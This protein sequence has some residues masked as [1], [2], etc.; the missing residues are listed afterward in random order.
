[1]AQPLRLVAADVVAALP[2][3]R[4]YARVLIG[5]WDGADQLVMETLASAWKKQSTLAPEI[6]LPTWLFSLMHAAHRRDRRHR[7]LA[8]TRASGAIHAGED[9]PSKRRAGNGNA[10]DATAE[11]WMR[12]L[13][14]P[15]EEREVL[16][17]AA[18][19]RLSYQDIA[20][21]L[22][23]PMATVM[24]TLIRARERMSTMTSLE[25]DSSGVP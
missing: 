5:D 9:E 15:V 19:E 1:M 20:T 7:G 13:R 2:R 4:R 14:L 21:L 23:V 10:G 22:D 24:S 3:L 16:M 6:D 8:P 18:V 11:V 12:V 17:L 25:A